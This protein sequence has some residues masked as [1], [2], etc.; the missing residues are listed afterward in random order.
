M[1]RTKLILLTL[2]FY[3][4]SVNAQESMVEETINI[5]GY[6]I[7]TIT[8]SPLINA[9]AVVEGTKY[10][11][12]TNNAGWFSLYIKGKDKIKFSYVGYN[13]KSISGSALLKMEQ[14]L[15]IRLSE[16]PLFSKEVVVESQA[17]R[18]KSLALM[19]YHQ[20]SPTEIKYSPSLGGESDILKTLKVYPGVVST[21]EI[22]TRINVR[23]GE[24]D[25]N[26][27]LVD[28]VPV[29]NPV[30]L[31]GYLSSFNTDAISNV[32][33]LKGSI[34][35]NYYGKIS[36]VININLK[37]GNQE[38]FKFG[39]GVSLLSS[40]LYAES[41]INKSSNFMIS[42]RRSYI[43][44]IAASFGADGGYRYDDIYGKLVYHITSEDNLTL[45]GYYG[46]D[47]I[48]LNDDDQ[49]I[50]WGNQV[51]NLKYNKL[52]SNSFYSD[53]TI[54]YSTYFTDIDW[55]Q[56]KKNPSISDL[57]FRI[58]NDYNFSNK[59]S[60]RSGLDYHSLQFVLNT[61]KEIVG[62]NKEYSFSAEEI[63]A[64]FTLKIYLSERVLT[65]T[66]AALSI[67]NERFSN[68]KFFAFDPR[69][70]ISY[71]LDDDFSIK[72]A[73]SG[74]HQNLHILSPYAL[75]LPYDIFYPSTKKIP[76]AKGNQTSIGVTKFFRLG[77]SSYEAG[78]D[79]Y[80]NDVKNLLGFKS[81]YEFHDPLHA[82]SDMLIGKGWG[83]GSEIMLSKNE[84]SITGM[85]N[86]TYSKAYRSIK[87]KNKDDVFIPQFHRTHY[88]NVSANY[89][90]SD[91]IKLSGT[92][93]LSSGQ[94]ITVPIQKYYLSNRPYV[95]YGKDNDYELPYYARMDIGIIYQFEMWSGKWELFGSVYNI[96][97]RKNPTW[98]EYTAH[99]YEI[100]KYS[101]GWVPTVGI[102]FHY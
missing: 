66:G 72:G 83:Y 82:N 36:S 4:L 52:W 69:F 39:G 51:V 1:F 42:A 54:Y 50:V 38:K 95:D 31:H 63:N 45:S 81:N 59:I 37:E 74:T 34:P 13:T 86:Y 32:E 77:G 48:S 25:Q 101:L 87:G 23:C 99:D 79:L 6:V 43:D 2:F 22:S 84:G 29:F 90:V 91:R 68:R 35:A 64:F 27:I 78:V 85:L 16:R 67:F 55:Y 9:L 102:K 11:V 88:L 28:G 41:P 73:Y 33:L 92:L 56:T 17:K 93:V 49:K 10:G 46:Y 100:K 12:T 97:N 21:S 62:Q 5:S 47:K 70:S 80:Y 26:L 8:G 20:L 76:A 19:G 40:Q 30:H 65:E 53:F 15:K 24:S 60:L 57:C 94:R 3:C 89:N 7:D 75:E 71:M 96:L 98:L 18:E 14:P 44:V 61:G 58:T